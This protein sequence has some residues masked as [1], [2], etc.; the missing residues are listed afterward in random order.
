MSRPLHATTTVDAP[1]DLV[2][3]LLAQDTA[4]ALQEA[5]DSAAEE[6]GTRSRTLRVEVAGLEVSKDVRIEVGAF[7]P[8]GVTHSEVGLRWHAARGRLLFPELT[9]SLRV[10]AESL[11]PPRTRITVD[12]VYVPPLGALGAGVDT[13]VLHRLADAT[14]QRF[15][16]EIAASLHRKVAALPDDE[17][18]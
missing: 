6:A 12:G 15:T 7:V 2:A 9:A 18:F 17:R 10:A 8:V 3:R 11:E 4:G 14:V 1:F 5:T 16:Q 13:L